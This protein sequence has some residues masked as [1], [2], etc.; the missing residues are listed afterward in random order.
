MALRIGMNTRPIKPVLCLWASVAWA[1][2]IVGVEPMPTKVFH[3][4]DQI[5]AGIDSNSHILLRS[6]HIGRFHFR[7]RYHQI[8]KVLMT[9]K[10]KG[11][12]LHL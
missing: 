4:H 10:T 9:G 1:V 5:K 3:E 2:W 12:R 6:M 7:V 8:P 11:L